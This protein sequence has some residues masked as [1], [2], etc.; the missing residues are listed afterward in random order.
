MLGF[1]NFL[2][3]SSPKYR[4]YLRTKTDHE[5]KTQELNRL[6]GKVAAIYAMGAGLVAAIPTQGVSLIWVGIA[7]RKLSLCRQ[8]YEMIQEELAFRNIPLHKREW[9]DFLIPLTSGLIGTAVGIGVDIGLGWLGVDSALQTI[10]QTQAPVPGVDDT[11]Q[12]TLQHAQVIG[13]NPGDANLGFREG[14]VTQSSIVAHNLFSHHAVTF[15][16]HDLSSHSPHAF[17]SSAEQDGFALGVQAAGWAQGFAASQVIPPM[18]TWFVERL[19]ARH[20]EGELN[21]RRLLLSG[22]IT[23]DHCGI[24]ITTGCYNHE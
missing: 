4:A 1:N 24:S 20:A 22:D 11:S 19:E 8:K 16:H 23:C 17:G 7:T 6:R 2:E 13:A 9:K 3:L 21:C 5:L 18:L 12:S 10:A 15:G 14:V